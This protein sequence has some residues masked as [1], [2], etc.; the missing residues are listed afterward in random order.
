MSVLNEKVGLKK[1]GPTLSKIISRNAISAL[2]LTKTITL[3]ENYLKY[4]EG[5]NQKNMWTSGS[6]RYLVGE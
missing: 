3:R 5:F 4:S 6:K 1:H 2:F